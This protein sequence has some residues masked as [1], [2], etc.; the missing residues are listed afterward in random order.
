MGTEIK[1]DTIAAN[2]FTFTCRTCGM[3]NTG[4]LILFLHGFPESS[5]MWVKLMRQLAAKNYRCLAFDLRGYSDGARPDG[6]EHYEIKKLAADVMAVADTL[7]GSERF[8]LV[9]HDWGSAIGWVVVTLNA[10]RIITWS[11][12]SNPHTEPYR[13]G[14]DNDPSQKEQSAYIHYLMGPNDPELAYWADDLARLRNLW[15]GFPQAQI[16]DYVRIFRDKAALKAA[17]HYYR[18][19]MTYPFEMDFPAITIPTL[20]IQGMEDTAV[21]MLTCDKSHAYLRGYYQYIQLPGADHWLMEK[22]FDDVAPEVMAHIA[23]FPAK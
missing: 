19:I 6:L 18:A 2:G 1:M 5:I 14:I 20:A 4:E 11:S 21:S 15:V 10:D 22:N 8:H 9:A 7:P 13:W 23:K 17:T 12:L 3:D 16:D